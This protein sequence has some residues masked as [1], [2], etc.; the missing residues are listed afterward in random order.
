MA[1]CRDEFVLHPIGLLRA[2]T[3]RLRATQGSLKLLL[4]VSKLSVV[5]HDHR[6]AARGPGRIVHGRQGAIGP[7][8]SAIPADVRALPSR[9]TTL[10]C[11]A[12]FPFGNAEFPIFRREQQ[13]HGS[14]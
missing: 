9:S 11:G 13:R 4:R 14:A 7:Q 1:D 8:A 2:R 3:Q 12:H 5:A 10:Q 6:K